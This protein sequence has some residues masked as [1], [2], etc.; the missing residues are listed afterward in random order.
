MKNL[1]ITVILLFAFCQ[2]SAQTISYD[3]N[4]LELL[5]LHIGNY[6]Q[7]KIA[8]DSGFNNE[9]TTYYASRMVLGDS[10]MTNGKVYKIVY[11][12]RYNSLIPY[13]YFRIDSITGCVYDYDWYFNEEYLIDSLKM[14]TGDIIING[15]GS[16]LECTNV[17]TVEL[18]GVSRIR[19]HFTLNVIPDYYENEYSEG[20]GE[21]Y[22]F[23]HIEYIVGTNITSEITYAKINGVEFG[24]LVSVEKNYANIN[25]FSLSQN[26][27]NPFNPSTVMSYQLPVSS[28]VTLTVYDVLGNE[29]ATLVNEE[30]PAGKYEVEFSP[31]SSIKHPV[32]GIYFY[33]LKTGSF[34]QTKKMLMIK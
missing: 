2:N 29:I 6:W 10:L 1:L 33:Q 25:S 18:F 30:K 3:P 20:L 5:P 31:E 17:D 21:T 8:V 7:Y 4:F 26:Y 9:D 19:K 11:D 15:E 27:P 28:N 12:T 23:D 34:V 14:M 24:Q 16:V 32:S 13:K 22:R